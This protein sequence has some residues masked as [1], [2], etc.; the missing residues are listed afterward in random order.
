MF[1]LDVTLSHGSSKRKNA[2]AIHGSYQSEVIKIM[3][4]KLNYTCE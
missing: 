2:L 1:R 3:N 4:E